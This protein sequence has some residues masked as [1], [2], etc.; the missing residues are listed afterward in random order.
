VG[1]PAPGPLYP[2]LSILTAALV[3]T[4]IVL[5]WHA[6]VRLE[7]WLRQRIERRSARVA[8]AKVVAT[9]LTIVL[10][11][12]IFDQVVL[13]GFL[14]AATSQADAVNSITPGRAFI[15]SSPM[16]SGGPGSLVSWDS[17]G[18]DGKSFVFSGPGA[19]RIR[20][21]TGDQAA[22][23]PIRLFA[24]VAKQRDLEAT[25]NLVLAEM[26]R[27][28]AFD[29]QA[30]LVLTSTSTGFINEWAA[31]SFEYLLRGNTAIVSMQYS[32]LP[33]AL[34]LLTAEQQPPKVAR[35]LIDAVA[36][37]IAALPPDQR[38]KLYAGGESL[39][40]YGGNGAF[41]SPQDMLDK[42]DGAL[43]TGTPSFTPMWRSLTDERAFGS[44]IVNPTIQGGEH[45]R[46]AGNA[47]ELTQDQFGHRYG[48]WQAP[49]VVYLQHGTDP[50][51]WWSTDLILT[52]PAWLDE[53]S[54]P[55]TP[56]ARMSWRPFVTFWQLTADMAMSNT[57]GAGFGHRYL[58]TETVPAWAG[59]L[60]LDPHADYTRIQGAI[61]VANEE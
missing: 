14:V 22:V 42:V 11:T 15:P 4:V 50:V 52:T 9:V 34:G 37:R 16:R 41:A 13:R 30:V 26:D 21:V 44:T 5:L 39:G 1:E 60:G 48:E 24:G 59:I 7:R 18:A 53:T 47:E 20:S 58:E 46:F 31:E 6:I 36:A 54:E 19:A 8:V 32:T 49:R 40:A 27:T 2:L 43:W 61:R 51:V 10:I 38:P 23:D 56:M 33:S 28:R 17:I 35:L 25:K 29:R 45:I 55:N 57:V 12:V 3:L